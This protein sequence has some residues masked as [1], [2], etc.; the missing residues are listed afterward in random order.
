MKAA[1]ANTTTAIAIVYIFVQRYYL[2]SSRELKRL[3][4]VSRSPIFAH[5]QETLG[6]AA[7][8]RAYRQTKRF[9]QESRWRMDE[10]LRAYFM[11]VMLNRWLAVRL[12]AVGKCCKFYSIQWLALMLRARVC[13]CV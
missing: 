11:W 13:V 5:F 12:E 7:T 3:D 9:E 1:S 8:I 2:E 10:N 4:S 6:G